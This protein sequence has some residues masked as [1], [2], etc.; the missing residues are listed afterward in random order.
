MHIPCYTFSSR[1]IRERNISQVPDRLPSPG[2]GVQSSATISF[3]FVTEPVYLP[4]PVDLSW[5][6]TRHLH[7][8]ASNSQCSSSQHEVVYR[9]LDNCRNPDRSLERVWD[10][11]SK[12]SKR[13][14]SE[15]NCPLPPA[16]KIGILMQDTPSTAITPATDG[17]GLADRE[18]RGMQ[19]KP[20]ATV[21]AILDGDLPKWHQG[22]H[23]W[24]KA[25]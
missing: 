18:K 23:R 24:G 11:L 4:V 10:N 17:T 12:V 1:S 19:Q 14:A 8:C 21:A 3:A 20:T 13:R 15:F 5:S 9:Y 22:P 16:T 7:V 25:T 2:L 6:T